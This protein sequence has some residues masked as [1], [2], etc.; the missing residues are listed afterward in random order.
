M[1]GNIDKNLCSGCK[2]CGDVCNTKAITFPVDKEGFWYPEVNEDRCTR[3]KQCIKTCPALT[4]YETDKNSPEVY[5]AWTKDESVR[6]NSTSGG[7]YYEFAK[8]V[9][10]NN[11]YIAGCVYDKDYKS[12]KHIVSNS[13]DDLKKIMGSK[14]FQ[15]NTEGVFTEIKKLLDKDN[16]VLFCGAPCQ[17]ASLYKFLRKSYK[18]LITIDF[19]CRGINSPKAF[20]KYINELEVKNKSKVNFV[21]LKDKRT[22]W[23]SLASNVKFE[24]GSEYHKDRYH[25]WWIRGYI[26]GNLY[27]RPVCHACQ[28]KELPRIADITIGDFWGIEGCNKED[29]FKGVS[30]MLLNSKVGI[31]LFNSVK[32]ELNYIEKSIDDVTKGNP[33]LSKVT[34]KGK[35]RD[36]FFEELDKNTF[37]SAVK[38]CYELSTV[39]KIKDYLRGIKYRLR[40][41]GRKI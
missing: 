20:E 23:Q 41:L 9:I 7:V 39:D 18:N 3:C 19:I 14:Y 40:F 21:R 15:S 29:M 12:A 4:G 11:G 32:N 10:S 38:N 16:V 1:I 8:Y 28:F 17:C 22:G 2:A 30:S 5:A 37:S 33:Y 31:D 26:C 24:N 36:L 13:I 35:N 6:L 27:M 25:D 34:E